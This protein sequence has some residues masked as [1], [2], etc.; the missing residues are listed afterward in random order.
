MKVRPEVRSTRPRVGKATAPE[1]NGRTERGESELVTEALDHL[2]EP[3]DLLRQDFDSR[4][5]RG[6]DTSGAGDR[7]GDGLAHSITR[8]RV[9]L[10]WSQRAR[11]RISR[12]VI[13]STF[14]SLVVI[15]LVWLIFT[16]TG[17]R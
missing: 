17:P 8:F 2:L 1:E 15:G 16:V 9:R 14:L 10:K 7:T 11:Y 6:W 4:L 13:A 3:L 5:A 12:L